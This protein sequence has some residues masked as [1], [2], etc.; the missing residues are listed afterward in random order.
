M[1]NKRRFWVYVCNLPTLK[2]LCGYRQNIKYTYSSKHSVRLQGPS[3]LD[4]GER[5]CLEFSIFL[6]AD[7]LQGHTTPHTQDSFSGGDTFRLFCAKMSPLE[8]PP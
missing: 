1:C 4:F 6:Q 5:N 7:F 2:K 8:K 3:P